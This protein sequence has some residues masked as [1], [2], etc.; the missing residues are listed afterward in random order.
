MEGKDVCVCVWG[1]GGRG[2][3]WACHHIVTISDYRY[4]LALTPL[5]TFHTKALTQEEE[6]SLDV[7]QFNSPLPIGMK[8]PY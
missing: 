2:R 3:G 4:F 6:I 1:G 7:R 8:A 5:L